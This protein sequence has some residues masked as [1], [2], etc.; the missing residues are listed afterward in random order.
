[1]IEWHYTYKHQY[2]ALMPIL[3]ELRYRGVLEFWSEIPISLLCLGADNAHIPGRKGHV[4]LQ[5]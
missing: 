4:Q 2:D 1:M 5:P 3:I